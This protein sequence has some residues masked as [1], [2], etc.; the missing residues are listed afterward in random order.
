[1]NHHPVHTSAAPVLN[2]EKN[3]AGLQCPHCQQ[4]LDAPA[5]L[6]P[7]CQQPLR[8][9]KPDAL[10]N[11]PPAP[12]Q[13]WRWLFRPRTV[14]IVVVTILVTVGIYGWFFV[15]RLSSS[16]L[17]ERGDQL[18][19]AGDL[20]G[21]LAAY[22]N[23]IKLNVADPIGYEHLGW[24]EYTLGRDADALAHFERALKLEPARALCITGAGLAAYRL[25]DYRRAARYLEHAVDADPENGT[26]REYLGIAKYRL[27]DFGSAAEHLQLAVLLEP[28][29]ATSHYYLARA[30]TQR[31]NGAY[32]LPHL[33]AAEQ[34][35]FDPAAVRFAR[36]LAWLEQ[37]NY[38]A[39]KTDL[40]NVT[41]RQ[42]THSDALLALA[43]ANYH[44][45]KYTVAQTQ[46]AAADKAGI[47]HVRVSY[48][49]LL[50]WNALRLG[51]FSRA[52]SAFKQWAEIAPNDANALNAL[53]WAS[54]S[55]GDCQTAQQHFKRALQLK[56]DGGSYTPNQLAAPHENPQAGLMVYC[57]AAQPK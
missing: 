14:M 9:Q 51:N 29:S 23:A 18:V 37:G 21:A 3:K 53:G 32:A 31:G 36:G 15:Q 27:D 38:Q 54:L 13:R 40:E 46:L 25:R 11:S 49:S 30:Q 10:V 35:G 5:V 26:I 28:E 41:T 1:M 48:F 2:E 4:S 47:L 24:A 50:G 55:A 19:A 57:P 6:C 8:M 7:H 20:D 52:Q 43:R 45:G 12:R 33:D 22:Q 34:L 44:L 16:Y 42:P 39:A 56:N 17:I